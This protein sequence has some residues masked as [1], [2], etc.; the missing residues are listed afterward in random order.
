MD[1]TKW[2]NLSFDLK[3]NIGKEVNKEFMKSRSSY[4]VISE[5]P[6]CK[7][8]LHVE[9]LSC[10]H[11][12]T[13]IQGQ[14]SLSKFNYLDTEQLYFIEVFVKNRGNIK[15]IEKEMDLSYPTIKKMLD[16]VIVSLGYKL[17]SSEE[18]PPQKEKE[19]EKD[20]EKEEPK[21]GPSKID[22]LEQLNSGTI[23]VEEAIEILKKIK[24]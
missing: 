8:D 12:G 21:A 2:K 18:F 20:K 19:K 6:V 11:C 7:H 23:K 3:K 10:S 9:G 16:E 5:C 17:D 15:A 1:K 22:I 4:P 14:F 24:A 13:T